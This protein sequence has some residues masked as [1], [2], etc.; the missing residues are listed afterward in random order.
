MLYFPG[1]GDTILSNENPFFSVP[2]FTTGISK[3]LL[4]LY[5]PTP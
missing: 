4:R 3:E 1:P 5:F 2:N